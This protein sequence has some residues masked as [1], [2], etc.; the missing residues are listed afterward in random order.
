MVYQLISLESVV[1]ADADEGEVTGQT[2]SVDAEERLGIHIGDEAIVVVVRGDITGGS[3]SGGGVLVVLQAQQVDVG[4]EGNFVGERIVQTGNNVEVEIECTGVTIAGGVGNGVFPTALRGDTQAELSLAE[5]GEFVPLGQVVTEVG[6]K[7]P[8]ELSL[9]SI[10][11]VVVITSIV[12]GVI[13]GA[14][15]LD[16]D[17]HVVVQPVADFGHDGELGGGVVTVVTGAVSVMVKTDV[18]TDNP[19]SA[20][21]EGKCCKSKG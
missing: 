2:S 10:V 7:I 9:G 21:G 8:L 16:T 1:E 19:L 15:E 6:S 20:S 12:S 17:L 18:A 4:V 11:I 13:I 5:D 3:G 14:S